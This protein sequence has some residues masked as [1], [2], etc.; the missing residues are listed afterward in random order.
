MKKLMLI[1]LAIFLIIDEGVLRVLDISFHPAPV[2]VLS[3]IAGFITTFTISAI[4][5]KRVADRRFARTVRNIGSFNERYY[6]NDL[7][8][9]ADAS[10]DL[11]RRIL[12]DEM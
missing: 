12:N 2:T 8:N 1:I 10:F 11:A 9:D 4:V 5:T 3:F 7:L 6:M